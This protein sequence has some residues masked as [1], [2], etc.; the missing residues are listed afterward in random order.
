MPR[1]AVAAVTK[2]YL[3][4]LII[5][6]FL[7][8]ALY[9]MGGLKSEKFAQERPVIPSY[10]SNKLLN[11]DNVYVFQGSQMPDKEPTEA[12]KFDQGDPSINPVDGKKGSP[13]S[14][15]MFSYNECK[16]ECCD[17]SPYSCSGGCVCM[18]KD[19]INFVGSRGT[20]NTPHACSPDDSVY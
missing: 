16:P 3:Y 14:M 19:Q 11:T 20:N 2:N 12:I 1:K 4:A 18:T 6:A 15:F 13:K 7:F 9:V 17:Y 5:I 8:V 10:E